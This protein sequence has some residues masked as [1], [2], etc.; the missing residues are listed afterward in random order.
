MTGVE[1]A[2]DAAAELGEGPTWDP[3]TGT[4][5]W[6]D[7]LGSTVH[8]TDPA[9]GRDAPLTTGQHVGAAKPDTAGGLVVNLVDGVGRYGRGGDF[10][11]LARWPEEGVRGNDAAVDPWGRLWAG[12][13]RY[14][15][16]AG[17]GRLR[18]LDPDGTVTVVLDTVTV[19][20]GI[21]WSPDQR[22]MYY[23]DSPTGRV[24]VFDVDT[25]G[26]VGGR[27]EFVAVDRGSPD[28]LCVDADGAVWVSLWDGW[29]VRRY[30]PDGRLDREVPVPVSR[31]SACTFG[32]P[33]LRDLY[34]TT[35]RV[36]LAEPEPHA[37]A[38]LVLPGAGHGL[39]PT[40]FRVS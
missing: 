16:G 23:I 28:G 24:D 13:M 8:R 4:L 31:P 26:D 22:L 2:L 29:A 39:P 21:G 20:N 34:I 3:A 6:V 1:V 38:L 7:I 25:A 35:A 30:T 27:R 36:G 10:R 14:D 15:E 5:V 19:S 11:W 40:P 18:R 37:G 32:G 9:T 12:T 17:G 33:D